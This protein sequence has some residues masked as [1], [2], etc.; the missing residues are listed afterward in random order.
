MTKWFE[1]DQVFVETVDSGAGVELWV[2]PSRFGF[3]RN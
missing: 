3:G 2:S 1:A